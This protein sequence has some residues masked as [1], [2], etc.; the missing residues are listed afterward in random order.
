MGNLTLTLSFSFPRD[1]RHVLGYLSQRNCEQCDAD[2][3]PRS[4]FN[5]TDPISSDADAPVSRPEL[6]EQTGQ[7]LSFDAEAGTFVR[8]FAA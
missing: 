3:W 5:K 8:V 6:N 2:L 7:V 1:D 4:S